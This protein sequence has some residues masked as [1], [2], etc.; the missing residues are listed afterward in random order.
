VTLSCLAA[1]RFPIE[2]PRGKGDLLMGRSGLVARVQVGLPD[3]EALAVILHASAQPPEV[4]PSPWH[5]GTAAV[6]AR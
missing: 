2:P 6:A 5:S 4:V 3:V 1:R